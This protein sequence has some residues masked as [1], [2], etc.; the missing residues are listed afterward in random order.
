[1][2]AGEDSATGSRRA[3]ANTLVDSR[4]QRAARILNYIQKSLLG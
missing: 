3:G 2:N 1:V 4:G